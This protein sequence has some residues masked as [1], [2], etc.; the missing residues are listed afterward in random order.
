MMLNPHA[1]TKNA[2]KLADNAPPNARGYASNTD[3]SKREL[4]SRTQKRQ[5][6]AY[7]ARARVCMAALLQ[8]GVSVFEEWCVV[9]G[10]GPT[11]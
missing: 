1:L 2:N 7:S 11:F 3:G 9:C 6:P 4:H 10:V 5:A 8:Q